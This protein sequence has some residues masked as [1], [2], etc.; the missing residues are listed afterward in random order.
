[1]TNDHMQLQNGHNI[2]KA[3]EFGKSMNVY[4]HF[5][6]ECQNLKLLMKTRQ[7]EKNQTYE[8]ACNYAQPKNPVK[9]KGNF[10]TL[11]SYNCVCSNY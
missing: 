2:L 1:M 3:L 9:I 10:K 7:Q 11:E 5:C 8:A 6:T 4:A